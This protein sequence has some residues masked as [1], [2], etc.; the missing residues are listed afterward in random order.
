MADGII[1]KSFKYKIKRPSKQFISNCEI[2][3]DA[4]RFVYNCAL[5]HRILRYQQG[6]PTSIQEQSKELT[7]ARESLEDVRACPRMI[8]SDALVRLNESFKKFHRRYP[9]RTFG[10][11]RFKSKSQYKT[12]GYQ[13]NQKTKYILVGD[14]L[15]IIVGSCRLF[16]SRPIEGIIKWVI[17]SERIDGWYVSL[18]CDVP[19]PPALKS[20]G[21]TIGIDLGVRVFGTLST[22]ETIN[23]LPIDK[24]REIRRNRYQRQMGRRI[25]GS[26]NRMGSRKHF[27]RL[28]RKSARIRADFHHKVAL[29]LV[30]R[31]DS[32][33]VEDLNIPKLLYIADR[34]TA[35]SISEAGWGNFIQILEAKAEWAG[36]TVDRVDPRYSSQTCSSCGNRQNMPLILR[37]FR[38][39]CC[40]LVLNR[41]HNAAVNIRQGMPEFTPAD[42]PN[43]DRMKQEQPSAGVM[44]RDLDYVKPR[45]TLESSDS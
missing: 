22:G 16:L 37:L 6:K 23:S 19:T 35:K 39:Q 21:A 24:K 10:F 14:R 41:D 8:Q 11:P 34:Q 33:K 13:I 29:D 20:T 43:R 18:V 15:N 25:F 17:V 26:S 5:E 45:S 7:D 44:P 36:R 31:F 9:T 27:A 28:H 38:C 30:Q 2:A 1:T 12:F 3:L 32:I 4:S 40:G 42:W